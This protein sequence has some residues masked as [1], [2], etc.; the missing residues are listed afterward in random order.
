MLPQTLK[1]NFVKH[2]KVHRFMNT[3]YKLCSYY[4]LIL[5]TKNNITKYIK[6]YTVIILK[7]VEVP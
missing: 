7:I 4:L 6:K 3:Y 1:Y 5:L 2:W